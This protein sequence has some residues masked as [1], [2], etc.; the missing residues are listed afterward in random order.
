MHCE[1]EDNT[2]LSGWPWALSLMGYSKPWKDTEVRAGCMQG[3]G[4]PKLQKLPEL[5]GF[6]CLLPFVCVRTRR[7]RGDGS[8]KASA[9][10]YSY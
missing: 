4:F 3:L 6:G 1:A 2:M 8:P 7:L 9:G 10:L 5:I